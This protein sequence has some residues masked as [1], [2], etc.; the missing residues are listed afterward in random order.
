MRKTWPIGTVP[1]VRSNGVRGNT[2]LIGVAPLRE[3]GCHLIRGG[4]EA[5]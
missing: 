2:R 4:L 3:G 5:A 1:T